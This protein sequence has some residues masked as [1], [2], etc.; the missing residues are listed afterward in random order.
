MEDDE[1]GESGVSEDEESEGEEDLPGD[2]PVVDLSATQIEQTPPDE[3]DTVIPGSRLRKRH[4]L[5]Q[6][7]AENICKD[8]SCG[9]LIPANDLLYHL[10]Y[11]GKLEKPIGGW[12][13]DDECKKN[14]GFTVRNAKRRRKKA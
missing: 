3:E 4:S 8:D 6:E 14:A 12:F 5:F 9:G 10:S 2:V 1:D 13:C 7:D 11:Q